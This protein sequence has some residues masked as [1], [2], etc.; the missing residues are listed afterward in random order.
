MSFRVHSELMK[1][2]E[3]TLLELKHHLFSELGNSGFP[4]SPTFPAGS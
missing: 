4:S 2:A 3:V 1:V